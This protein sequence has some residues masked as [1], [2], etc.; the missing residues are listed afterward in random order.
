MYVVLLETHYNGADWANSKLIVK[1]AD[2]ACKTATNNNGSIGK[3]IV[4]SN[5]CASY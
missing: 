1:S 5:V 2:S 3:V 4:K